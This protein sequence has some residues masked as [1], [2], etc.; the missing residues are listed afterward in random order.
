ML[1]PGI[2]N[3]WSIRKKL[4]LLTLLVLL[5]ASGIV[6]ALGLEQRRQE[7]VHA[8]RD[9]LLLV[10][11]LAVRQEQIAVGTKQM[12]FT[13]SRLS[14]VSR[15]DA[16][17]CHDLFRDLLDQYPFYSNIGLAT[18]DGNL[19]AD[20]RS[21]TPGAAV[22]VSEQKHIRDAMTTFDFSAG[23]YL[24]GKVTKVPSIHYSY[25]VL[26]VHENLRGI[27]IAGFNLRGYASFITKADLPEGSGLEILD[28]RGMRIYRLPEHE[29]SATGNYVNGDIIRALWCPDT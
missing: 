2:L 11:S 18:P 10:R 17:A 3:S 26:D 23:E 4:V 22:N 1:N 5:P 13:L 28:H 19:L 27:I 9:A 20:A 29:A 14:E 21:F 25:P 24:V 12:L 8:E 16:R 6:V 15:F 7:I